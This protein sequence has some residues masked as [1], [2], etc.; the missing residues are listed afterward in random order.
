MVKCLARLLFLLAVVPGAAYGDR[1][2]LTLTEAV[3]SAIERNLDLRAETFGPALADADILRARGVFDPRFSALLDFRQENNPV[4][5]LSSERHEKRYVDADLSLETLLPAGT[6]ASVRFTNLWT[7]SDPGAPFSLSVAPTLSAS[8]SHPLLKGGGREATGRE[9]DLAILAKNASL[10]AWRTRALELSLSTGTRYYALVK[11]IENVK[12]RRASLASARELHAENQARVRAGALAAV[13]LLDSEFGVATRET[14]LLQAEK[15]VLDA[16]D[17]LRVLIQAPSDPYP[18][19]PLPPDPVPVPSGDPVAA[20]LLQRPELASARSAIRT[21]ERNVLAAGNS[22][23]PELS[24]KGT[25]GLSGL[26]PDYPSALGNVGGLKYP[27]VSVGL[28][29]SL[30]IRNSAARADFTSTRLREAQARV[31]LRGLEEA[32]SLEVRNALRDVDTKFRQIGTARKGV[33]AAEKKL[34]SYEK[35]GR[36]GMATTRNILD[37]ERDLTAS[38]EAYAAARADYEASVL[39]LWRSTGELPER[40]GIRI[41]DK[42]IDDMARTVRR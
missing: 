36:L 5:P 3:R 20:A 6:T 13:E 4:S 42:D 14:E 25:A 18:A 7:R 39:G 19:D 9:I 21:Q 26:A 31:V 34:S 12:A 40:L 16:T 8:L 17:A 30:P 1:L 32:V 29:L 11:A 22:L 2:P 33:L 35:R 28:E 10:A 15:N 41:T 37:A 38:R 23:L 27:F 24:V